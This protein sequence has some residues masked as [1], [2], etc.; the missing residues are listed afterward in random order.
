MKKTRSAIRIP[1]PL[2]Y[3]INLILIVAVW[4]V[5]NLSLIHI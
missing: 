4:F 1:M 2:R 3:V 5:L